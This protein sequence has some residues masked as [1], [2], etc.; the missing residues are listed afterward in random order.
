VVKP[1]LGASL[2]GD[3][4]LGKYQLGFINGKAYTFEA[5]SGVDVIGVCSIWICLLM[6]G[7][8]HSTF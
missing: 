4:L 1:G 8:A 7:T 3:F 6:G 5:T 2:S